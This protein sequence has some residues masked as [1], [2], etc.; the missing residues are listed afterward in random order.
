MP[1]PRKRKA[2]VTIHSPVAK[3]QRNHTPIVISDD[4]DDDRQIS[5]PRLTAKQK[6]KSRALPGT[7][8][9]PHQLRDDS[10]VIC[11]SDDEPPTPP[12]AP[13]QQAPLEVPGHQPGSPKEAS[14]EL[15]ASSEI[16]PPDQVLEQF[17]D[18][19]FDERKC[20]RCETPIRPIRSPVCGSP[21][22]LFIELTRG[23]RWH[24][25]ISRALQSYSTRSAPIVK[26]TTVVGACHLFG[27]PRHVVRAVNVM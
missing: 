21:L 7:G 15:E 11:I 10:D 5:P 4:S 8:N 18:L 9:P 23:C 25:Q 27:A 14:A 26:S 24:R 12:A 20:S 1:N 17:R 6:G 16:H 3:Q 13:R 22:V 19:F 2:S